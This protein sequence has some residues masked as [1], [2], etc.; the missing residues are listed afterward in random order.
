MNIGYSFGLQEKVFQKGFQFYK[1]KN[2]SL[3]PLGLYTGTSRYV[4]A[5]GFC[6]C[7]TSTIF[8]FCHHTRYSTFLH[9]G[10]L[11]YFKVKQYYYQ[12]VKC[13][14]RNNEGLSLSNLH[15]LQYLGVFVAKMK[16]SL[17]ITK[18]TLVEEVIPNFF[19]TERGREQSGP[20]CTS[21]YEQT[22]NRCRLCTES[23]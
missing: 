23:P 22:A 2:F 14:L 7:N 16:I 6:V 19:K 9:I 20:D 17:A 4:L 10:N 15:L 18:G 21:T 5:G 3:Y 1:V 8:L 11:I 13:F 12:G